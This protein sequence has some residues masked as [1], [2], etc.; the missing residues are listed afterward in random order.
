[1]SRSYA[2]TQPHRCDVYNELR[3][4]PFFPKILKPSPKTTAIF[5]ET[6][7]RL[8]TT[9]YNYRCCYGTNEVRLTIGRELICGA[10]KRNH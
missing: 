3:I 9:S 1:M 6:H 10:M 4:V 2:I 8:S 7:A 5:L